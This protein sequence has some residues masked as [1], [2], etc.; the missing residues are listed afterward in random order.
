M[1]ALIHTK[2]PELQLKDKDLGK[3]MAVYF[4]KSHFFSVLIN[5]MMDVSCMDR[6]AVYSTAFDPS[7]EGKDCV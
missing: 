2:K 1:H 6:E 4:N 7:P 5:S 3:S